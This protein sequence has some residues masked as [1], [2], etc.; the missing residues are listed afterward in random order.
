MNIVFYPDEASCSHHPGLHEVVTRQEHL[1][2]PSQ[3]LR[4]VH[5]SRL[6]LSFEAVRV[7]LSLRFW[8]LWCRFQRWHHLQDLRHLRQYFI[9]LFVINRSGTNLESGEDWPAH[10]P[11]SSSDI[12][13]LHG[14]CSSY[15]QLTEFCLQADVRCSCT[16]EYFDA[17]ST[18]EGQIFLLSSTLSESSMALIMPLQ[19]ARRNF[20]LVARHPN[21][22]HICYR[23]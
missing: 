10:L 22:C 5:T 1:P 12:S 16:P 19:F 17:S 21:L 4:S 7:S 14:V 15:V 23:Q 20:A 8:A 2:S 9:T 13:A 11:G 3:P 18:W 6:L